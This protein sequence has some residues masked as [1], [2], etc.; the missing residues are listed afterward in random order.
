MKVR[1]I[2]SLAGA[3]PLRGGTLEGVSSA[4]E[5]VCPSGDDRAQL[6]DAELSEQCRPVMLASLGSTRTREPLHIGPATDVERHI[7]KYEEDWTPADRTAAER[8]SRRMAERREEDEEYDDRPGDDM[9]VDYPEDFEKPRRGWQGLGEAEVEEDRID[10]TCRRVRRGGRER[11]LCETIEG[12]ETLRG[13]LRA[14]RA[15]RAATKKRRKRR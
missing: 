3:T 13:L 5:W 9:G 7:G 4:R 11:I 8:Y 12:G 1:K 6:G 10:V 14:R 15:R 2:D